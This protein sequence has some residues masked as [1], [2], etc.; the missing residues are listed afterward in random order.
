MWSR[1]DEI[2]SLPLCM[3][4]GSQGLNHFESSERLMAPVIPDPFCL[5]VEEQFYEAAGHWCWRWC[6]PVEPL[7]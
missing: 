4:S 3:I 6:W 7:K 5:M 2:V 1:I